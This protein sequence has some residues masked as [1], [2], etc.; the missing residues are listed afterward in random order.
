MSYIEDN[1]YFVFDGVKS[2]DFGVWINGGGT[3]NAAKRRFKTYTVPGRNGA[4]TIDEGAFEEV[5]HTYQAFIARDFDFNIEAFRNLIMSKNGYCRLQ[6]SYHPDEF[7]RARYMA[8]LDASV[9]PGGVA[10]KFNVTF[11]RD[12]RRF[13]VSGETQMTITD[14]GT[15][16]NPTLYASRPLIRVYG[17]GTVTIGSDVITVDSAFEYVDIDSETQDCYHGIDNANEVVTFQ[18]LDFPLFN[19]G[20]N[21]IVTSGHITRLVIKPNWW[22]V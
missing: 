7:Y 18:S 15:L 2:S 8:G 13:L 1:G 20:G 9:A 12:P 19:P 11:Q 21:D 10:G 14:E 6:D 22:I 17:Y 3:Y 5:A 16:N 4:L